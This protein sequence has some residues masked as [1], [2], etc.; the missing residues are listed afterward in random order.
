M[1]RQ[2]V[3]W[4]GFYLQKTVNNLPINQQCKDSILHYAT[5]ALKKC[6]RSKRQYYV[7]TTITIVLPMTTLALQ[8]F[9]D[10]F[11]GDWPKYIY[12]GLTFI[13]SLA[14]ALLSILRCHDDWIRNR[15]YLEEMISVIMDAVKEMNGQETSADGVPISR[16]LQNGLMEKIISIT[17]R[18]Q[19][20]WDN[21]KK[22][23]AKLNATS[24]DTPSDLSQ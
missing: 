20:L 3:T 7:Y 11:A 10:L 15:N 8:S 5:Y 16:E 17:K 18:H 12:A 9:A 19:Q 4:D 21:E 22:Q 2:N 24:G 6:R 1:F 23:Q 13:S 14:A